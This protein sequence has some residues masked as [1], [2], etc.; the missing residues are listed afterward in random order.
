MVVEVVEIIACSQLNLILF[1]LLL[2]AHCALATLH[3]K[4]YVFKIITLTTFFFD[5][6]LFCEGRRWL[7]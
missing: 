4:H 7:V 1:F 6:N 2:L 3:L 5:L